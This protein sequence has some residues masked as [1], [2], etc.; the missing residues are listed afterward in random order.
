[1][2]TREDAIKTCLS[3]MDE[4]HYKFIMQE[5]AS[6]HYEHDDYNKIVQ[7]FIKTIETTIRGT[8]EYYGIKPE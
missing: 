4:A 8:R 6:S 1:M 2:H 3:I 7:W 5:A